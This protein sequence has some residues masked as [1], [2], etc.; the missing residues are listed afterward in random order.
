LTFDELLPDVDLSE[1]FNIKK[2]LS[3]F[4][5][6]ARGPLF[7]FTQFKN[8]IQIAISRKHRLAK[9]SRILVTPSLGH[10]NKASDEIRTFRTELNLSKRFNV[11]TPDVDEYSHIMEIEFT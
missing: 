2:A 7:L 6:Q 1:Y 3:F 5:G 8:F 9:H 4:S 10:T 11:L